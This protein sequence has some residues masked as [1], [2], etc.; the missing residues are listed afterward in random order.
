MLPISN[1]N[2]S[3]DAYGTVSNDNGTFLIKVVEGSEIA[4]S[5]I[6]YEDKKESAKNNMVVYLIK[7]LKLNQITVKS[8]LIN[9]S[10]S[11]STNSLTIIQQNDIRDSGADHLNEIVDRISNLNWAG[12]TSRPRYFQIR[13]F[14]KKEANISV[15]DLLI[16][17]W[18]CIR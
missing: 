12:G 17:Y 5:H 11:E 7:M 8:G 3:T 16:F 1:V 4:F 14:G 10:F 13:G 18:L 6:G 9:E 2:I 15:K